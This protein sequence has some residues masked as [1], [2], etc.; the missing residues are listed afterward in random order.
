[1]RDISAAR[2]GAAFGA[3]LAAFDTGIG[4]GSTTVGWLIEHYGFA[5]GLRRRRRAVRDRAAVLRRRRSA[6]AITEATEVTDHTEQRRTGDAN[7]DDCATAV[8]ASEP[9]LRTCSLRFVLPSV[10]PLRSPPVAPQRR[11]GAG[12]PPGRDQAADAAADHR[13]RRAEPVGHRARFELAE[14]RAAHEEH[15]VDADHAAAQAIGRLELADDV[16]DHHA[17]RVGGA[18]QRQADERQPERSRDAEDDGRQ[19]RSRRPPRAAS[20]RGARCDRSAA[21]AP[22][23]SPSRR[24]PAPRTASRSPWRR[25]AGCPARRSAAARSPT[26]RTSRRNRAASSIG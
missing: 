8:R 17:D 1:M 26:R 9:A 7:G 12:H 22:R 25:P 2:R 14:L 13:E 21:P 15:H 23:W 24:P 5:V 11:R 20:G 4:T 10:L 18:G 6:A 19:R 16:A 3:I